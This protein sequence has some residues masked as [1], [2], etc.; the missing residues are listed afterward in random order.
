MQPRRGRT[1]ARRTGSATGG[2]RCSADRHCDGATSPHRPRRRSTPTASRSRP[3]RPP[4]PQR[5]TQRP[6]RRPAPTGGTTSA[7]RTAEHPASRSRWRRA[8]LP[9]PRTTRAHRATEEP[10]LPATPRRTRSETGP[11]SRRESA[12]K[13]SDSKRRRSATSR[14]I[15]SVNRDFRLIE[16]EIVKGLVCRIAAR[17][18][19]R[20]DGPMPVE[21]HGDRRIF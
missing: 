6:R 19:R 2:R 8:R 15:P 11:A 14:S 7:A 1:S 3:A 4:P 18:G 13:R 9:L 10:A 17:L 5:R 16:S 21:R 12:E 20:N